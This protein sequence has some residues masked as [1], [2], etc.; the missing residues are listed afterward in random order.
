MNVPRI[1]SLLCHTLVYL[2]IFLSFNSGETNIYFFFFLK[3]EVLF[4]R[5]VTF[6]EENTDRTAEGNPNF[7]KLFRLGRQLSW[8]LQF[9]VPVLSLFYYDSFCFF[10]NLHVL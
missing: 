5:D 7:L 6:I 3:Y 4:M 10:F 8:F 1:E 9:T 2:F